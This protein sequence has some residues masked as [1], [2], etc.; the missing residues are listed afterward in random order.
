MKYFSINPD[1]VTYDET[2]DATNPDKNLSS[3]VNSIAN[4]PTFRCL[5]QI[6]NDVCYM[7][8]PVTIVS[9]GAGLVY[10]VHGYSHHAVEDL[11]IM[12][13]LPTM[14]IYSPCDSVETI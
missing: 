6:R 10:G 7:D 12:R 9:V 11:A 3:S 5:E 1:K 4:F 2:Y 13:S 8:N 14:K